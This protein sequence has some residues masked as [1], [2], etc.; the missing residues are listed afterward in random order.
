MPSCPQAAIVAIG[1]ELLRGETTDTNSA[2]LGAQL[3]ALGYQVRMGLTVGDNQPDIIAALQNATDRASLVLVTGGLGPTGDDLTVAAVAAFAGVDLLESQP[4]L[5]NIAQRLGC[6]LEEITA[7]RRRMAQIPDGAR[8]FANP[9][10]VAPGIGLAI[11]TCNMFLLPGVPHEMKAIFEESLVPEIRQLLPGPKQASIRLLHLCGWSESKADVAARAALSKM[12][13]ASKIEIG[14]RLGRGGLSFRL[15]SQD[16]EGE[17]LLEEA[18]GVL[19]K[20][21]GPELWGRDEESLAEK[22]VELLTRHGRTLALAESC[23]GGG[24]S[25]ELVGVPGVSAVLKQAL[26]TY[27]NQAKIDLL[28]VPGELIAEHGAVS[29]QCATAMARGLRSSAQ[30]DIN[31]SVTGIAGP[32]GGTPAKPVGTVHFSVAG[33]EDLIESEVHRFGGPRNWVRDRAISHALWMIWRTAQK[34]FT[35]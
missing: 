17:K 15:T 10:G 5:E 6:S 19:Q 4:A 13:A 14:T 26:V 27:S 29:Q 35:E 30:A 24:I 2:W 11:K 23:T 33:P 34:C 16:A 3:S 18:S 22:V 1:E 9:T 21:F 12:I 7:A 8:I 28:A 32:D 25:S 20:V 31:L